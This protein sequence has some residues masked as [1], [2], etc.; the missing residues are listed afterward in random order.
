[1]EKNSENKVVCPVDI[2]PENLPF[3]YAEIKPLVDHISSNA[4]AEHVITFQRGTVTEDNRL[5]C[6][7]QNLGPGGAKLLTESLKF[8]D[9][10]KSILFGTGGIGNEGAESVG[11]LLH[12]NNTIETVYLGCNLI[13]GKGV[14]AIT[15][16]LKYNTGVKALWLK[17]N[18]IGSQG[19][20]SLIELFKV[21]RHIKTLDLVNTGFHL[22]DLEALIDTL[23]RLDYPIERLYLSGN[24][25]SPDASAVLNRLL[26]NPHLKELY[27]GVN[28]LG[29]AGMEG[30]VTNLSNN[31]SLQYLSLSSNGITSRGLGTLLEALKNTNIISLDLGH[32]PSTKVLGANPNEIGDQGAK[33]LAEFLRVNTTLKSLNI[34]K[35]RIGV[36]GLWQICDALEFNHKLIQLDYSALRSE[37]VKAKLSALL[38]RNRRSNPPLEIPHDVL[39]IKSV[40]R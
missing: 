23:V 1:M 24:H 37:K 32:L 35:N 9:K 40:Y 33:L 19:V 5:D 22:N 10:I 25:L 39:S 15:E 11:E 4:D 12:T 26:L 30:F 16:G 18:P 21:N 7:K 20:K 28:Q 13:E 29:D 3:D 6:C 8:N 38:E 27:L 34:R 36:Y 31:K 2:V 17:R 14:D